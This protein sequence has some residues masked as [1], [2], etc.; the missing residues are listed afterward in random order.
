MSKPSSMHR[1]SM[2]DLLPSPLPIF[3]EFEASAQES[4]LLYGFAHGSMLYKKDGSLTRTYKEVRVLDPTSDELIAA[5]YEPKFQ[6]P[7]IDIV[8]VVENRDMFGDY[9]EQFMLRSKLK[10]RLNYFFTLNVVE[11]AIMQAEITS[12]QPR[13]LKRILAY[14]PTLDFG[15]TADIEVARE[16]AKR[17]STISDEAFQEEFAGRKAMLEARALQGTRP[18]SLSAAEY[19]SRFPMFRQHL[20]DDA[21][22]FPEDRD[23]I[24]LPRSM[25]LKGKRYLGSLST[26]AL[27]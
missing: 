22:G 19:A 7:D 21:G 9:F 14:R 25:D 23:K 16:T 6:P 2:G 18:F 1:M 10:Q 5:E 4:S 20:Q 24:V 3:K 13:A 11:P 15:D 27:R 8:A 17:H 26:E 12:P